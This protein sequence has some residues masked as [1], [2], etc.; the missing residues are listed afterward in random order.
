MDAQ[1]EQTLATQEAQ[2]LQ[3]MDRLAHAEQ[4]LE[5]MRKNMV[6]SARGQPDWPHEHFGERDWPR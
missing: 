6:G 3:L 5:W 2:I 4:M 1:T